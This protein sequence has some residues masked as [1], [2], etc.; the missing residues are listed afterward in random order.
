MAKI[1][2]IDDEYQILDILERFLVKMGF[3]VIT[4]LGGEEGIKAI[5]SQDVDLIILD[6]KMPKVTGIDV[7]KELR[8][9][10][11]RMPVLI[12]SGSLGIVREVELLKELGYTQEDI[13]TKPIDLF[14]LLERVR[15]KLPPDII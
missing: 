9:K 6:M 8:K 5:D 3:Q 4:A 1:L 13:V 10:E 14:S 15:S 11:K 2:V 12:L 7:L